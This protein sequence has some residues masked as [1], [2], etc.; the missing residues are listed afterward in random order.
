V[1][2]P[3][4]I[5]VVDDE[6]RA[7]ESLASLLR[8]QGWMAHTATSAKRAMELVE[9]GSYDCIL[10]D[11][12]LP[13]ASGLEIMDLVKEKRPDTP[14]I[15][16]TGHP[17]VDSAVSCLK[18]GAYDYLKKPIDHGELIKRIKNALT[19]KKLK[20]ER[21]VIN[22]K[23][24]VSEERYQFLVQ[25]S[26]DIIFT[27]DS[28]GNFSF[29]NESVTNVLGYAPS[30]LVGE[31]YAK[32]IHPEDHAKAEIL[33]SNGISNG[34]SL[35]SSEI[36]LNPSPKKKQ[37]SIHTGNVIVEMKTRRIYDRY[38]SKTESLFLGTYGVAQD[39]TARKQAEE[40][41]MLQKA[42][43]QQLFENSPEAIVILDESD[44]IQNTNRGFEELFG[45][46]IEE[47][48]YRTITE[49]IVP[50][51]RAEE[52]R[53]LSQSVI[54]KGIAQHNETIRKRKDGSEVDVAVL[55]YP[56][57]F[58]NSKVGVYA[59]YSDITE[60]KKSEKTIQTTL[61]KL[62]KA[63]GG[64]IHVMVSTVEARDPYT[65]GHQHR[66]AEL[67]RAIA[68][69][70]GMTKEQVDGIRIA[71]SIHDL[72][73]IKIPAEI[74]SNPG[75]ITEAEFS[76]IKTHP[77][78][79]YGILREIEFSRPVAQIVYQ[80]HEKINGSG[81]PR[82]LAAEEILPEAKV[83]TIADVVEAIA[84]HRPYRPALGIKIALDEITNN[85]GVLYDS[86]AADACVRVFEQ[87]KFSLV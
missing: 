35:K 81:Y 46:T 59:I 24:Q 39:I 56:I 57:H 62:R 78:V 27:L 45:Y 40:E 47:C 21:E 44:R 50:E 66:V 79:A 30:Q 22:G 70:M 26:P 10:L 52:A 14:V 58:Q 34:R 18:N 55:G 67:A 63:M 17:S 85:R 31:S 37:D 28:D 32:V 76:L 19:L 43:F 13:E 77:E 60:R 16:V 25:N 11:L 87:N 1:N 68:H 72:G 12:V 5:L 51:D 36:R 15:I 71:G 9:S 7:A 84:S 49:L 53:R 3:P 33:F 73:K 69:E 8:D 65:A 23:L 83:L 2:D 48:Q 38:R 74:L 42:H 54:K 86:E 6:P 20:E 75:Q 41:L 82:G 4:T 64:I 61:Q 80:H 29:I